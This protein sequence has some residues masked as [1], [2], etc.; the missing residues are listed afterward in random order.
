M[1]GVRSPSTVS[2]RNLINAGKTRRRRHPERVAS[3]IK[4]RHSKLKI[5]QAKKPH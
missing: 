2:T 1:I 3:T 5:E 4:N